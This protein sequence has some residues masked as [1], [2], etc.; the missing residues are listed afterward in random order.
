MAKTYTAPTTVSSG[1]AITASL[2]N[3]YVS[4]NVAN[5]IVPPTCRVQLASNQTFLNAT[6]AALDYGTEAWDTDSMFT[7]ATNYIEINTAG[8]YQVSFSI[9]FAANATNDRIAYVTLNTATINGSGN[10]F[11][12][13]GRGISTTDNRMTASALVNLAVTDRLRVIGYQNS[14]GSLATVNTGF[15]NFLAAVWVGRTS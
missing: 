12:A 4:T 3:T 9:N 5:L 14:G 11:G 7:A 13:S 6:W 15:E 10:I 2:Y 8:L 1:D